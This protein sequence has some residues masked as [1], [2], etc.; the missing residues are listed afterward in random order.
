M[1]PPPYYLPERFLRPRA[2]VGPDAQMLFAFRPQRED[3]VVAMASNDLDVPGTLK[4]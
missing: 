3:S 4:L 2:P 1:T